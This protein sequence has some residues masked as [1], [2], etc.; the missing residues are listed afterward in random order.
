M[1]IRN[2]PL[3][4]KSVVL[5]AGSPCRSNVRGRTAAL[6][7]CAALASGAGSKALVQNNAPAI[8]PPSP[9]QATSPT[10][11]CADLGQ[12]LVMP[13]VI[14][15]SG[16]VLKGVVSVAAEF[17]RLPPTKPGNTT[18]PQQ[19]VRVYKPGLPPPPAKDLQEPMPGPTLL[20]RVGD[21][22][23]LTFVNAADPNRFDW[24]FVRA[25]KPGGAPNPPNTV[26]CMEVAQ[27]GA[28]V[29]PGTFDTFPNCLHAS[30]TANIHFHGTH[31]NPGGIGDDV[32]LQILPLPRDNV[33]NLTTTPEEAMAGLDSIFENCA[34]QLKNPLNQ[35][36]SKWY[37][38]SGAW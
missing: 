36:P 21:L 30:S 26:G 38:I 23:Q 14:K 24:N 29:Y 11:K 16:N 3:R 2:R 37:D 10:V 19:L 15:A 31:T 20:A 34:G 13:P 18:C 8:T 22:V 7:V 33:G 5:F 32:F 1:I 4:S 27:A 6:I 17:Q 9:G 25:Q 35:W 12:D 28:T